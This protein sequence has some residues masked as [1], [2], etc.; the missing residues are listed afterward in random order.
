MLEV[1]GLTKRYGARLAVDGISFSVAA[2]DVVGFLGPNGAGKS[3]TLRMITGFLAPTAGR[4]RVGGV[5]AI[6]APT[7]ARRLFGYMPEG[8]PLHHEMR[9]REYLAFRAELKGLGRQG[10]KKAVD[11]SL[12]Q[13]GVADAADRIVG[14]LSKGYRQRVGLADA[15]LT[16]PPLLILDEP[17][18]GLD[19]NQIR[20]IRALIRSF[21]GDKAVFVSTHILPEVQAT[22]DRVVIID[23]GR[24]VGEGDPTELAGGGE[25]QRLR[26]RGPGSAAAFRAALAGVRGAAIEGARED[27]AGSDAETTLELKLPRGD[28]SLD[29]LFAAVVAA[30]LGIRALEPVEK[31]LEDVFASLTTEDRA[32]VGADESAA[33]GEEAP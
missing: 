6:R 18:A 32:T 15:L 17:T 23:R 9:A 27:G 12:E 14:Q 33:P 10:A 24:M 8:V 13:A 21:R 22:C 2:G 31:D 4:V 5:D 28:A 19:P 30:G 20:Q 3:T 11:R 16:D 26:L 29:A 25:T 7:E 1:E